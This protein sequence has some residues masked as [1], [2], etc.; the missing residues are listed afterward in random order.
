MT[1]EPAAPPIVRPI[2]IL[3]GLGVLERAEMCQIIALIECVDL[4]L[5][6]MIHSII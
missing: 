6:K 2:N 1:V 3:S 4:F 5:I